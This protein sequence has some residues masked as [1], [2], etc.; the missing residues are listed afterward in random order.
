MTDKAILTSFL[1]AHPLKSFSPLAYYDKHLDCIRVEIRDC[2]VTE[3]RLDKLFTLLEDNYPE[4][5]QDPYVGFTIKGVQHLF[6]QLNL[7]LDGVWKVAD[8]LQEIVTKHPEIVTAAMYELASKFGRI[9]SNT[10]LQVDF[11]EAA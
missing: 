2:S 7:P 8:L 9:L 6:A 4:A 10:E 5:G 1:E 3:I 11:A